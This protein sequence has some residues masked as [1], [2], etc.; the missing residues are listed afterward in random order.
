MNEEVRRAIGRRLKESRKSANLSQEAVAQEMSVLRQ[1]VSAWERGSS[2]PSSAA[3]YALGLMYGC[4]L[5]YLVYGIRT[6]P[7]SQYAVMAEVFL[8]SQPDLE[9]A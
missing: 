2:M 1:T 5:D 6:I 9:P 7:V 4:S 3:W 8:P